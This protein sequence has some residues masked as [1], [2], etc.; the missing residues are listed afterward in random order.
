MDIRFFFS[1]LYIRYHQLMNANDI[2][3]KYIGSSLL[4]ASFI[5]ESYCDEW[6]LL[7]LH[8]F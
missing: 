2:Y 1:N 4:V 8:I 5:N 6:I 7:D 3:I